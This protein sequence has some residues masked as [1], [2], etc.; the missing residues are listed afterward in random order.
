LIIIKRRL[1]IVSYLHRNFTFLTIRFN[2]SIGPKQ[3]VNH[4]FN[5]NKK[6]ITPEIPNFPISANPNP[7]NQRTTGTLNLNSILPLLSPNHGVTALTPQTAK[8]S[9]PL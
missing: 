1:K 7:Q 6:S 4:Q 5:S 3:Y 9:F 8:I 2:V